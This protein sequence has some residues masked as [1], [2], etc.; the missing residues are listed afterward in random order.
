MSIA[1]NVARIRSEMESA[2]LACGRDPK[3]IQLCADGTI[4]DTRRDVL[5]NGDTVVSMNYWG[6]MPSIF[7]VMEQYFEDFLHADTGKELK[8]EC[9]LPVMVDDLKAKNALEVSVLESTDKWFGMT[10]RADREAVAEE[11][12]ALHAEGVYPETLRS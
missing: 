5:L 8:S 7:P 11:L 12:K 10:Y 2:A 4:K 9:L 3:E 6:F 1:E